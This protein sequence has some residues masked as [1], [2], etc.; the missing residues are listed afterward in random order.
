MRNLL[1][2]SNIA[3]SVATLT[4]EVPVFGLLVDDGKSSCGE[5]TMRTNLSLCRHG[6]SPQSTL[7]ISTFELLKRFI[8][9]SVWSIYIG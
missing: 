5:G 6:S 2:F 8:N 3:E 1:Q 4:A 9:M 7:W